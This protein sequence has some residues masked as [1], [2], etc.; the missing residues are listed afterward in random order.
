M[1]SI[2]AEASA[3]IDARPETIYNVLR[4][5]RVGHPAILP[6]PYFH[7]FKLLKGGFG[8]GT[9]YHLTM[10]VYGRT[11]TCQQR[12]SEP[13]PGRVIL[14]TDI[15]TGQFS[16]FTLD[17]V[18]GGK[19]RVTI[20][21]EQPASPGFAGFMER[22]MT[23]SIMRGIFNKELALLAAYVTQGAAQPSGAGA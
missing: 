20:T 14:E 12:I 22:L 5:Y 8:A 13:E 7:E 6:K 16:R 4:D 21:V 18:E 2:H 9:E 10:K 3:V 19:T 17:P 1:S 11:F 15:H 23:P